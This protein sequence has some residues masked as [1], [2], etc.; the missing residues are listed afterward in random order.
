[1]KCT[2][3]ALK[4]IAHIQFQHLNFL[5]AFLTFYVLSGLENLCVEGDKLG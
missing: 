1:M 3:F 4:T 5:K 2:I